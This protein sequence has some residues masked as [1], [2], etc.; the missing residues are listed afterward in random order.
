MLTGAASA[1]APT[2][3]CGYLTRVQAASAPGQLP[4]IKIHGLLGHLNC[5]MACSRIN[6]RSSITCCAERYLRLL[7][8][9]LPEPNGVDSP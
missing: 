3:R 6:I 1:I 5:R 8:V 4:P 2:Y 7:V 9:R